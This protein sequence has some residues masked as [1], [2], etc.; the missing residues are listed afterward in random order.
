M[1]GVEA[2]GTKYRVICGGI[3]QVM[4]AVGA[5]IIGIIAFFI[6]DWRILQL[7]IALPVFLFTSY[8]WYSY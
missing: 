3:Y 1:A 8:Y 7:I 2:V 5:V 4:Y 6:R